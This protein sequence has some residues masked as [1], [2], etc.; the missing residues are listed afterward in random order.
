MWFIYSLY[1]DELQATA[2]GCH[3]DVNGLLNSLTRL[4]FNES[5]KLRHI[6]PL[7]AESTG[8]SGLIKWSQQI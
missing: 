7:W 3:M 4:T 8:D 2:Q 1:V 6:A 5:S